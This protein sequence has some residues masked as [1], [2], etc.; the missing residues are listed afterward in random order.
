MVGGR[1]SALLQLEHVSGALLA[2]QLSALGS[3]TTEVARSVRRLPSLGRDL[4]YRFRGGAD[5]AKAP[6]EQLLVQTGLPEL[7]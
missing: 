6:S 1:C 4:S 5:R 3:A 7:E 2:D